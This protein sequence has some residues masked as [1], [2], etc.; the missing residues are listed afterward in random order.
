MK[1]FVRENVGWV[2]PPA[3]SNASGGFNPSVPLTFNQT[4][5]GTGNTVGTS[6]GQTVTNSNALT[7]AGTGILVCSISHERTT[8][9]PGVATVLGVTGGTSLTWHKR[10]SRS[11]LITGG[12]GADRQMALDVWWAYSSGAQ[13]SQTIT[14][15]TDIITDGM[16]FQVLLVTGFSGTNWQTNPW[17]ANPS[18]PAIS[19]QPP[20]FIPVASGVST[21]SANSLVFGFMACN[22]NPGPGV[23]WT[24]F[25]NSGNIGG[26]NSCGCVGAVQAFTTPITNKSFTFTNAESVYILSAD[27]L[28]GNI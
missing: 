13:V 10:T 20:S 15:T 8:S 7:T 27:A 12:T 17:D 3:E 18:L 11:F 2:F 6:N 23:N 14:V 16:T 9:Q 25:A 24:F 26:T 21:N 22:L 5:W 28:S 4:T 19:M 1:I